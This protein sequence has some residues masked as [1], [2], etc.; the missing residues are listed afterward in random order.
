MRL[1]QTQTI[2]RAMYVIERVCFFFSSRFFGLEY[3]RE[4][5]DDS[6]SVIALL[7]NVNSK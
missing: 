5:D 7:Q 2:Q 1:L 3:I 4:I 6:Q